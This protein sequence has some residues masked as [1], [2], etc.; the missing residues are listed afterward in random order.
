MSLAR[1]IALP[2][3]RS[4]PAPACLE[5]AHVERRFGRLVALADLNL[6]VRG[7]ETLGLLGPNGAGKTTLLTLLVGADAPDSGRITL[8]GRDVG[9]D[10]T[11]AR[12]GIAPQDVALY[13]SLTAREN[14]AFAGRLYGLSGRRLRERIDYALGVAALSER[15]DDR[16]GVFSG[17]M[18]RRLN[19]ACA[20]VHEPSVVL[21]DEPTAGVDPQ[22]RNHI[23]EALERLSAEGVTIVYST[24]YMEEAERLCDRIAILDHGRLLALGTLGEL[25]ERHGSGYTL[26]VAFESH[27]PKDL[28]GL[29]S[30]NDETLRVLTREPWKV[31]NR[32]TASGAAIASL[33]IERPSLEGV[34]LVLTGRRLRD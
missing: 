18:Q 15:A 5:V 27:V 3:P 20:I 34:F 29:G 7:G 14:L 19:L 31:V 4:E 9:R 2:R 10:E 28:V 32:I 22:S 30:V 25:T 8:D 16:V 33:H 23:F 21:L 26:E 12:I 13:G 11:R 17:G 1:V 24:H 6:E